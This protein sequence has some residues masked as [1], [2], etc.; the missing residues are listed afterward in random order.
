M[1]L[2]Y[3]VHTFSL[4]VQYF[5]CRTVASNTH[6]HQK[7]WL[8]KTAFE[9]NVFLVRADELKCVMEILMWTLTKFYVFHSVILSSL[10]NCLLNLKSF[11][12]E[13]NLLK[14]HNSISACY[15]LCC[16]LTV[17]TVVDKKVLKISFF[18]QR[19]GYNCH[20]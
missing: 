18:S 19:K 2:E 7:G 6:A 4:D 9:W 17:I 14:S 11:I 16:S 5:S 12:I 8:W 15:I 3:N 1:Y 10:L 13:L 20:P